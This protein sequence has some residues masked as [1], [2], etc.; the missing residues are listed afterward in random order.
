MIIVK[1]KGGLGNQMF[2][3]AIGRRMAVINKAKLKLDLTWFENVGND[4]PRNY[5]LKHYRIEEDFA[6]KDEI[7]ELK[8]GTG[9]GMKNYRRVEKKFVPLKWRKYITE[10]TNSFNADVLQLKDN[11]YLDGVWASHKYFQD[12]NEVILKEFQLRNS[13]NEANLIMTKDIE[14]C[15][16]ISIH[17]RR[18]DYVSNPITNQYHG[19]CSIEYYKLAISKIT[20]LI[21]EPI[22]YLFSD[23]PLW[24]KDNL[25]IDF[26]VVY[27]THNTSEHGHED[28]KLM[29]FCKH[30]IIANSSFS[31]WAAWLNKNPNKIIFAP[32]KWS[33]NI[34]N[35]KFFLPND[36]NVL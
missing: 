28:L 29:Q 35:S 16:S 5:E 13:S 15:N 2:Q 4:T 9:W 3:Y 31:W 21:K 19:L 1:L 11:I 7:R 32:S 14:S 27:V 36:W 30:N 8:R 25:R 26:P 12:V 24:V 34:S 22:F 6:S 10:S 18:G 17:V 20:K 33:N 23:D